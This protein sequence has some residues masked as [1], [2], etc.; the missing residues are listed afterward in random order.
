MV[1]DFI[2]VPVLLGRLWACLSRHL[3]T[4]ILAKVEKKLSGMHTPFQLPVYLQNAGLLS[5]ITFR[6]IQLTYSYVYNGFKTPQ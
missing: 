3:V 4:K 6:L 1:V 5:N 2:W